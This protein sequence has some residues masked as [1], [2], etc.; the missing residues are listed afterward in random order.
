MGRYKVAPFLRRTRFKLK[1]VTF[2]AMLA[3]EFQRSLLRRL[4]WVEIF[5]NFDLLEH[6]LVVRIVSIEEFRF[7]KTNTG[8]LEDV[9]LVL[10]LDIFIINWL[11]RLSIDPTGIALSLNLSVVVLDEAHNPGHLNTAFE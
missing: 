9:L 2:V 10:G 5:A 1:D 7:D 4:E 11:A 8:V 6:L 3:L